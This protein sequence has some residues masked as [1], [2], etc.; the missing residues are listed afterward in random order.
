MGDECYS[1]FVYRLVV[2]VVMV[3]MQLDCYFL[4]KCFRGWWGCVKGG[5][6]EMLCYCVD[7]D[8]D[9]WGGKL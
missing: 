8:V 7:V 1:K 5:G 2:T 6:G 3:G 9:M 4:G